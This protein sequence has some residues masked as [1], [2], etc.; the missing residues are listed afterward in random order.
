M[1]PKIIH[2]VWLGGKEIPEHLKAYMRTWEEKM[3]GWQIMGWN[4]ANVPAEVLS[5][6]Y[7]A[8][9]LAARKYAFASDYIRLWALE[10]FGGVYMDTDVEVLKPF[11]PLLV[12]TAFVGFEECLAHLP[13]TCLMGCEAHCQWVQDMLATYEGAEFFKADG[14]YDLTTNVQRMGARMVKEG[15]VANG[16]EQVIESWGL[17][18]YP[19]DYFSPITSTRVMR[20]TENTYSIHHFASSWRDQKGFARVRDFIYDKVLGREL[21]DKLVQLK[22]KLKR[23]RK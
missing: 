17:H 18:V 20:K 8:E 5:V 3:P 15:M 19:H 22:R 10:Q 6:P 9:A 21:V 1:I 12:D 13:A 23:I 7:V 4:E 16:V 2:Y 11:E 14:F